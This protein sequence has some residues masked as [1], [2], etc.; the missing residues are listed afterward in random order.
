MPR[1]N[2]ARKAAVRQSRGPQRV[3]GTPRPSQHRV[4]FNTPHP[5]SKGVPFQQLPPPTGHAPYHMA[6]QDIIPSSVMTAITNEGKMVFHTVGDTGG[7]MDA[8]PQLL[9]ANEMEN[10]FQKPP[11]S[12]S[13]NPVF[14]YHL[15]DVIYFKGEAANY[16]PQFY[17]PY[18][19]Y[20]AP[21]VAIPGNHDGIP[22]DPNTPSLQAFMRNFCSPLP[23]HSAD[24]VDATRTTMTLPNVYWTFDTPFA[25]IIGWYTNTPDHGELDDQ[26]IQW[27]TSELKAAPS[28]RALIVAMHHP[29]FSADTVHSGSQYLEKVLNDAVAASKRFPDLVLTAHV[30]NYQRFTRVVGKR[31]IPY[32][33]AGAGG[34]HNLH[35]VAKVNGQNMATPAQGPEPGV[36]LEHYVDNRHGFLRLEVTNTIITGTYFVA[37]RPQ[38][39]WRGTPTLADKFTLDWAANRL[40][41]LQ[42]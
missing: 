33:V 12:L 13:D 42:P 30:H 7:I 23:T 24:A 11:K 27:L 38:E 10:D 15:G 18:Q 9:V 39:P 8:T 31:Q 6:L 35:Y 1:R 5:P 16:Y 29:I 22:S 28:K 40:V 19:H 25:T 36:T 3:F 2:P 32:I 37:P 14:F 20:P 17:E 41:P 26:Q 34:Y 21:I 4:N